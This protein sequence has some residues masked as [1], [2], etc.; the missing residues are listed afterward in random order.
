[1]RLIH[2]QNKKFGILG[3]GRYFNPNCAKFFSTTGIKMLNMKSVCT[4][5]KPSV[6]SQCVPK[7]CVMVL[8]EI[9]SDFTKE[10]NSIRKSMTRFGALIDSLPSKLIKWLFGFNGLPR[11]R[12]C[13]L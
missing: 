10:K 2:F 11:F 6:F 9:Y 7:Y 12:A 8:E 13:Y 5:F 4:W 3:V 1:M